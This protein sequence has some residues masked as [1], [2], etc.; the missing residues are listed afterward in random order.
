MKTLFH[1]TSTVEEHKLFKNG[2]LIEIWASKYPEIFD[3]DDIRLARSQGKMGLK[4][5]EWLSAITIF[6]STG[7]RV[8]LEKFEMPKHE[9][10][11]NI[12]KTYAPNE[13][14][15]YIMSPKDKK[16]QCPDLFC[17]ND[18][19][20]WFFCEVKG[21]GDIFREDQK[22]YFNN[23]EKISRKEI[24]VIKIDKIKTFNYY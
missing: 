11:H 12:F 1:I 8:L 24:I 5:Y 13:V 4:F 20:D 9:R 10:K 23:I 14:Y 2:H 15:D 3:E 22:E 21:K 17:Y 18:H 19:G 16:S 7:Y 6:N